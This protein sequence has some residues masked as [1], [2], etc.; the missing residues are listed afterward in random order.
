MRQKISTETLDTR[1]PLLSINLFA[2]GN[3]LKHIT[4]GFLYEIFGTVRQKI[5]TEA[6]DTPLP[7]F[8]MNFWLPKIF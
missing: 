1:P 2:A 7:P 8:S 3:F 6:L 5:S 4:E